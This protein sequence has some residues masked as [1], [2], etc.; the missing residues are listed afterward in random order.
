MEY[1]FCYPHIYEADVDTYIWIHGGETAWIGKNNYRRRNHRSGICNSCSRRD[2]P[3]GRGK[4]HMGSRASRGAT[5]RRDKAPGQ[6]DGVSGAKPHLFRGRTAADGG[7]SAGMHRGSRASA[8]PRGG[9]ADRGA[10]RA[11]RASSGIS[12]ADR[13]YIGSAV[14][15]V[16]TGDNPE[17]CGVRRRS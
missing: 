17:H 12:P 16:C 15:A 11:N 5:D 7:I 13:C 14:R 2:K 8:H 1:F 4:R 9:R 6:H 10:N 3:F